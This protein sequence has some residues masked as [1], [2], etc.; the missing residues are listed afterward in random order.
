MS[1]LL[2]HTSA[3]VRPPR[4]GLR[5]WFARALSIRAEDKV[6]QRCI[7]RLADYDDRLLDDVG[8]TRKE[9]TGQHSWPAWAV[10]DPWGR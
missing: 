6:R 4:R 7:A 1:D 9:A 10:A 8:L 5:G 3:P 2:I